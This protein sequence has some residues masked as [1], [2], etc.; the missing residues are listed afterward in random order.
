MTENS[1]IT[2]EQTLQ[3]FRSIVNEHGWKECADSTAGCIEFIADLCDAG[4]LPWLEMQKFRC[5]TQP[6]LNALFELRDAPNEADVERLEE[7]AKVFN[8]AMEGARGRHPSNDET[9]LWSLDEMLAW[10]WALDRARW[11]CQACCYSWRTMHLG[12]L[13]N[14][15]RKAALSCIEQMESR[16]TILLSG[17]LADMSDQI[18]ACKKCVVLSAQ[19]AGYADET[20]SI[21]LYAEAIVHHE[22]RWAAFLEALISTEWL[23]SKKSFGYLNTVTGR[24]YR[25]EVRP[26]VS[27]K[28][29]QGFDHRAGP[30]GRIKG[31]DALQSSHL[32]LDEVAELPDHVFLERR[33]TERSVSELRKVAE[34][35][36]QLREYI[37]AIIRNPKWKRP[38]VWASLGWDEKV[39]QRVDRRF[40]RLRQRLKEMG[41]GM[42][43]REMPSPGISNASQTTYFETLLEG[44][45]GARFGVMQ[46]K[47]LKQQER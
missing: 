21:M 44:K 1:S 20:A 5:Q 31:S 14:E 46:H 38:D 40:R 47:L 37:E 19:L 9:E 4:L 29:S 28:D 11:A 32:K 2:G 42:E 12:K 33:Y 35:D 30:G 43:W 34:G 10:R 39:G 23:E 17:R 27:G 7:A 15:Q 3:T 8:R 6:I 18:E 41:A 26:D 25:R 45:R 24:L 22:S 16:V 36:P 13:P